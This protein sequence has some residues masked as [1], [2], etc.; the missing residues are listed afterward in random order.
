MSDVIELIQTHF[1]RLSKSEKKVADAIL[2]SPETAIHTSIASMAVLA[3]VSEPTVNRFCRSIQCKGFPDFKLRLAQSLASHGSFVRREISP[4]DDMGTV[5]EKVIHSTIS[6]LQELEKQIDHHALRQSVDI[7]TSAKR[8]HFYGLGA[9]GPV[10]QD[11][12]NKFFRLGVPVDASTDYLMQKMTAAMATP[13]TAFVVISYTGRT[14]PL[15]E[16]AAEAAMNG[17]KVI[18]LTT[19]G[20]PLSEVATVTVGAPSRENTDLFTPMVSRMLHLTLIDILMTGVTLA[21]GDTVEENF[22]K[23]KSALSSTRRTI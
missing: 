13:D 16:V 21:K 14:Q 17:G 9:S 5:V 22:R 23:V 12:L 20:S 10:A 8:I 11:A 6:S 18:A 15:I 2:A 1:D 7:L 3:N 19:P 4:Q